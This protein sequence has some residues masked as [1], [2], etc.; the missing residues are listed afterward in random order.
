[1]LRNEEKERI[2]YLHNQKWKYDEILHDLFE[3]RCLDQKLKILL[4]V[5]IVDFI[6][7]KDAYQNAIRMR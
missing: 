3:R 7:G 1:M 2:M 5:E 4:Y 6:E